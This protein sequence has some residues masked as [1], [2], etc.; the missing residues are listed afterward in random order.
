MKRDTD[1]IEA[2]EEGE[3]GKEG[4]NGEERVEGKEFG[5]MEA[6]QSQKVIVPNDELANTVGALGTADSQPSFQ[7]NN[8]N[9]EDQQV[10]AFLAVN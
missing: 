10:T 1:Q 3:E 2:A 4:E 8:I 6:S 7:N 5:Q 9:S